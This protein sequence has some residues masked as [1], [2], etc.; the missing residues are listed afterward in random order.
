[1]GCKVIRGSKVS[2]A[3][4]SLLFLIAS[5]SA[6]ASN[7]TAPKTAADELEKNQGKK[8][9]NIGMV[10]DGS[11]TTILISGN[12]VLN[13]AAVK[14][15]KPMG[16][17]MHFPDTAVDVKGPLLNTQADEAL[18][19]SVNWTG[20]GKDQKTCRIEILLSENTAYTE[21]REG[22][23]IKLVFYKDA[24]VD[25]QRESL[26]EQSQKEQVGN[27]TARDEKK[28]IPPATH[29]DCIDVDYDADT[30][31]VNIQADGRID[32][33]KAF[34]IDNPPRIVVD[35]F[36]ITGKHQKEQTI[37][38]N[39]Q[40][41]KQ[42]RYYS[43]PD[44]LRLVIDATARLPLAD[45]VTQTVENGL[46]INVGAEGTLTAGTLPVKETAADKMARDGVSVD[47]I[48][49]F[50]EEAGKSMLIIETDKPVQFDID[51]ISETHL[52]LKLLNTLLPVHR[53]RPL[54]TTRFDSAVDRILPV[55]DVLNKNE[56]LFEI[57]LREAVPYQVQ[58]DDNIIRV[59]FEA[60]TVPPRPE[61][62]MAPPSFDGM[63]AVEDVPRAYTA[64]S[65]EGRA[66]TPMPAEERQS[67]QP[68][69]ALGQKQFTGEKIALDFYETDIKNVFRILNSVSGKNLAV[70]KDVSGK[71]TMALDKP[72]PWDQ[73]LDLI[74]RMN[75]LGMVQ[76]G[77]IIRVAT[78]TTLKK[79]EDLKRANMEAQQKSLAQQKALEPLMTEY[80]AINYSSAKDDVQPHLDK[81]ST[82]GRG[83]ISV[84][85]R[86]NQIIMTDT[87]EQIDK[88]LEIVRKIDQVTPQ[89]IIEARIVEVSEDFSKDLGIDWSAS[90]GP[91]G[92]NDLK[93][94][95]AFNFP[96]ASDSS[97]GIQLS[98]I[99]GT[100]FVLNATLTALETEGEAEVI[101][102]PKIIT[103]DN[104]QATIKQG[105]E[106]A[107]LERDDSGGSSIKF[108]DV[109]LKLEVTPHVTPDERIAMKIMIEKNDVESIV[110]GVPVLSTNGAETEL[111]ID[112]GD[113]IVI[114]GVVKTTKSRGKNGFPMLAD[115]PVL[116]ALFQSTSQDNSKNELLIF[117]TPRIIRLAQRG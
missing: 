95:T 109:D 5:L 9:L 8:I 29:I 39:R 68:R 69:Y 19:K 102:S 117:I 45:Y 22:N 88:A 97:M 37:P 115:I 76:E 65:D 17:I 41:V 40:G 99:S 2:I 24:F 64:G 16:V 10:P 81:L 20:V 96:V 108:K 92:N 89:V 52:Q 58:Q 106:Y 26:P 100:P 50:A 21:S 46:V 56:S 34:T 107:Y 32:N 49:F 43:Y 14:Q 57:D 63:P 3:A 98:S 104:T 38:V 67:R 48:D 60:S 36:E 84:D 12:T 75:Q 23:D 1:M 111:L 79:E 42:I 7:T 73:V 51:R 112:D 83:S 35:V 33:Y 13:Y 80:I 30:V 31:R 25:A 55:Q 28:D 18:I 94:D 62:K 105:F 85:E 103:L 116:G 87:A 15:S 91:T 47:R 53:R 70:D 78:L 61:K 74:L 11:G 4:L 82:P 114:G 90:I 77:D 101:S 66:D 6:C 93:F 71:V 44:R 27:L 86:T 113:T 110:D 54:I 59:R 72:V